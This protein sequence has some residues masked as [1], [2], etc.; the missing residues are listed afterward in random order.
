MNNLCY[1]EAASRLRICQIFQQ[2]QLH[3]IQFVFARALFIDFCFIL[4]YLKQHLLFQQ[5]L[6][7]TKAIII[8]IE[9]NSNNSFKPRNLIC[10]TICEPIPINKV[11][12][13]S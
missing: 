1:T 5:D 10:V 4:K 8:T 11:N 7:L 3:V 13:N 6:R 12:S 2:K 9:N